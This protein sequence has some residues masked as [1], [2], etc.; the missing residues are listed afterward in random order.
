MK[1]VSVLLSVFKPN[2]EYLIKQLKSINTQTYKNVE[3]I[4]YDD[5][6]QLRCDASV[7]KENLTNVSYKLL[8]YNKKNIGYT[9]AFQK[10]IESVDHDGFV[11]FCDQ[12]DIWLD[13][14]LE[15]MISALLKNKKELAYCDRNEIDSNDKII[16]TDVV[17]PIVKDF[18][19]NNEKLFIGSPFRTLAQGMSIVCTV[20]LAKSVLP[21]NNIAF[22]K[23]LSCVALAENKTVH[24]SKALVEYRRHDNNV[25]GVLKNIESKEDYI[26]QRIIPHNNVVKRLKNKYNNSSIQIMDNYSQARINKKIF[27]LI[28]YRWINKTVTNFEI[29][30][31]ITPNFI[32]NAILKLSKRR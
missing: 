8:S 20:S 19:D 27:K 22:D 32:F 18:N 21:F 29:M 13:N 6:P 7:F 26:N 15:E 11:A 23:W 10:L 25:S 3:V 4:I 16:R 28:K 9:N 31:F 30:M 14:K 2:K 17:N 1:K 5:C 12:D 24:V